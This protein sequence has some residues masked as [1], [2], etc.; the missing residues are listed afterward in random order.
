MD[1]KQEFVNTA[2]TIVPILLYLYLLYFAHV[3]LMY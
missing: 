1:F 2:L 3:I